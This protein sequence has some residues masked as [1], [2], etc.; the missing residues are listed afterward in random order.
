MRWGRKRLRICFRGTGKG[1]GSLKLK[2]N[3]FRQSKWVNDFTFYKLYNL[4]E[5]V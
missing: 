1:K 4:K 2:G 3:K 5:N